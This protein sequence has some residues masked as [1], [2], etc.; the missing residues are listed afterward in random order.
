MTPRKDEQLD[1]FGVPTGS[2]NAAFVASVHDRGLTFDL[3]T[4]NRRTL[5]G[6]A[7]GLGAMAL[8]GCSPSE[9]ASGTPTASGTMLAASGSAAPSS[10]E[11]AAE[12]APAINTETSGPFPADG[13]NGVEIRTDDG[14]VRNDIRPSF[15]SSSGIAEGVPLTI[16]LKLQDLTC[17]PLAGA[18]V[19][20]WHC[21]RDGN[22]SLYSQGVTDQNYLRGVAAADAAGTVEFTSIFPACYSGRWPHVH[23]EVYASVA[24]ATSGSGT[25]IKTSQLA[26]PQEICDA[27]YATDGYSRSVGNLSQVTL[28]TDNVFGDDAAAHQVGTVTG[29]IAGGYAVSLTVPVDP[30][31][32][33]VPGAAPRGSV[34]GPGG[35]PGGSPRVAGRV[36]GRPAACPAVDPAERRRRRADGSVR[37][38]AGWPAPPCPGGRTDRRRT[39]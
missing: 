8:V 25:V 38:R 27:V 18:A 12:C 4:M 1:A 22:Y 35:R 23:F 11:A 15:G 16:S 32:T 39:C 29:G 6:L 37:R 26:F 13:S 24:D 19:Y 21:D 3:R 33:E 34:G 2:A 9:S 28:A 36:V 31:A 14:V 17:A 5:L 20:V 7:G 30:S 10:G